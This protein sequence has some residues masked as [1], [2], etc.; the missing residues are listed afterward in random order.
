MCYQVN[1]ENKSRC[2]QG[3]KSQDHI[4]KMV[5]LTQGEDAQGA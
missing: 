2:R 4:V 3:V 1:N 5:N